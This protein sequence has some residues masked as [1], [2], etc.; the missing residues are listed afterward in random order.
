MSLK[1]LFRITHCLICVSILTLLSLNTTNAQ[2]KKCNSPNGGQIRALYQFNST[3]FARTPIGIYRSTDNANS[4]QDANLNGGYDNESTPVLSFASTGSTLYASMAY[5]LYISNDSGKSWSKSGK[6]IKPDYLVSQDSILICASYSDDSHPRSSI[7][8]STTNGASWTTIK[9]DILQYAQIT[10]LSLTPASVLVTTAENGILRSTDQGNSWSI[11]KNNLSTE[12]LSS[13]TSDGTFYYAG[14]TYGKVFKSIDDGDSWQEIAA[15]STKNS[16]T[17]ILAHGSTLYYS[18]FGSGLFRSIDNAATWKECATGPMNKRIYSIVGVEPNL[19]AY[20]EQGDGVFRSTNSGETWEVANKGINSHVIL[21]IFTDSDTL[22]T[23]TWKS[24]FYRSTDRAA[25]WYKLF[26]TLP[27]EVLVTCFCRRGNTIFVG[28]ETNGVFRSR[29][30]G[31][32]WEAI[33]N[34]LSTQTIR[35]ISIYNSTL[36]IIAGAAAIFVSTSEG[37]SWI[38]A[39]PGV[40]YVSGSIFIHENIMLAHPYISMNGG[41]SWQT[42]SLVREVKCIVENESILYAGTSSGVYKSK[43]HGISWKFVGLTNSVVNKITFSAT[44]IYA[45]CSNQVVAYSIDDGITWIFMNINN[46]DMYINDLAVLGVTLYAGSSR[47]LNT[48]VDTT[49]QSRS[50][51]P[52]LVQNEFVRSITS[53]D[54]TLFAGIEEK[55]V[56]KSISFLRQWVPVNKGLGNLIVRKLVSHGTIL[57]AGTAEGVYISHDKGDH[58]T[59]NSSILSTKY[60]LSLAWKG[61]HLFAGTITGG[62]YRSSDSAATWTQVYTESTTNSIWSIATKGTTL[63]AGTNFGILRSVDNGVNWEDIQIRQESTV[64]Y[65]LFIDADMILAGTN[66]NGI[67]KSTDD[68]ISWTESS[69]GL[70]FKQVWSFSATKDAIFA[71]TIGGVFSSTDRGSTWNTYGLGGLY[72]TSLHITQNALYAGSPGSGSMNNTSIWRAF[73]QPTSVAEP[74]ETSAPELS[75]LLCYPNPATT[76]LTIDYSTLPFHNSS[77]ITC[78]ITSL[79]GEVLRQFELQEARTTLPMEDFTSGVY[80]ITLRQGVQRTSILF[81]IFH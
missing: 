71:G 7:S 81:S 44:T 52:S 69:T 27:D 45:L 43:D 20:S 11:L 65:S 58:W 30:N 74:I 61:T 50:W 10:G 35:S 17:S 51:Y 3:F 78:T 64:V 73:L 16:V 48:I 80:M 6:T 77:P 2:W 62:I 59:T 60:I 37:D 34:G 75:G 39:S 66:F 54:T 42:D 1:L 8:R 41:L 63:F 29:D 55:G 49:Q 33:S 4:W 47:G 53:I 12:P 36:C 15:T 70:T 79:T 31:E 21:N 25:S 18:T 38:D 67:F 56:M 19:I 68:G 24:G 22:Y 5:G 57:V 9:L 14:T 13:L 28:T 23:R 26:T 32:H 72:I 76:T 40:D 46:V